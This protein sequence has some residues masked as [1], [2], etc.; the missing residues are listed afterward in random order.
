VWCS[1]KTSRAAHRHDHGE[2]PS[3]VRE[4]LNNRATLPE[5]ICEFDGLLSAAYYRPGGVGTSFSGWQLHQY[6]PHSVWITSYSKQYI[7]VL[8]IMHAYAK[9]SFTFSRVC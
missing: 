1:N 6:V 4:T 9:I 2:R 7:A 5:H 3:V 8:P